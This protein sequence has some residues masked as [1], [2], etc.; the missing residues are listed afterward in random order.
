[1]Q[2]LWMWWKGN[3]DTGKDGL[4]H[5]LFKKWEEVGWLD[6][7]TQGDWPEHDRFTYV[8]KLQIIYK[9]ILVISHNQCIHDPCTTRKTDKTQKFKHKI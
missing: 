5:S 8:C 3:Y 6:L 1:M 4:I 2:K 9:L 7:Q